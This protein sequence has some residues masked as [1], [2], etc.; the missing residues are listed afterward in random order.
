MSWCFSQW[1]KLFFLQQTVSCIYFYAW[2]NKLLCYRITGPLWTNPEYQNTK[3][4]VWLWISNIYFPLWLR[5]TNGKQNRNGMVDPPH[6]PK[7]DF[8]KIFCRLYTT[9]QRICKKNVQVFDQSVYGKF[10]C[11]SITNV[12][13]YQTMPENAPFLLFANIKNVL[14]M[15][16]AVKHDRQEETFL[17][18][19]SVY[20]GIFDLSRF[21]RRLLNAV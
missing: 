5:S 15:E 20:K 2:L 19:S 1:D 10:L 12:V 4:A 18:V 3:K 21:W 16:M 6:E 7:K 11:F 9:F 13:L 17:T 8:T 14:K